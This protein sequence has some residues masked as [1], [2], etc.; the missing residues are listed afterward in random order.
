MTPASTIPRLLVAAPNSGSG[1]TTVVCALLAA[2]KKRGLS[3]T[4]FIWAAA[5]LNSMPKTS[6]PTAACA[7][8]SDRPCKEDFP[9]L[10]NVAASCTS[11]KLFAATTE[12]AMPGSVPF[13][14][15]LS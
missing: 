2:L 5:I 4:A 15:R 14:A 1:K 11:I 10:P 6:K 8:R 3:L 9:A 12:R 7:V 13:L